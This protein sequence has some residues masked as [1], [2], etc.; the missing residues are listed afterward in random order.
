MGN[1]ALW[2]A[3]AERLPAL[4]IINNNHSFYND[5]EH[6]QRIATISRRLSTNATGHGRPAG[7]RS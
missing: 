4:F 2:T 3:A 5:V 7:G 6:Q 1:Q